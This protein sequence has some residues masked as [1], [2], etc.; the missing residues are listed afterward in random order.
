MRAILINPH[1]ASVTEVEITNNLDSWY[2]MLTFN[3]FKVDLVQ[4]AQSPFP[5]VTLWVDEEGLFKSGSRSFML[6]GGHPEPI[7]GCGLL[8]GDTRNGDSKACEVPLLEVQT[9]YMQTPYV[10]K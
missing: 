1:I 9:R 2:K 10:T 6:I 3:D 4:P 7:F 8:I 5:N